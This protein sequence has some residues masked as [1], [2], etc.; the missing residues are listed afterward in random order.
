MGADHDLNM[1]FTRCLAG[2]TDY[3]LGGFR[4]VSY[5]K[6]EVVPLRPFVTSTRCHMLAMYVTLESSL[7]LVSDAPEAYKDQPGFEFIREVPTTWDETK[8]P[9]AVVDEY[10]VTAR[11]KGD[12][13]YV[14]GIGNGS[15]R[16][17]SLPLDF[18]GE[19]EYSMDLYTDADDCD[20]DPNHLVKT[21]R[22]VGKTDTID[23]HLAASGGFA[24][25][26]KPM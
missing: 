20:T 5:D 18:L 7:A 9:L 24:A 8:V 19:G 4:A 22:N 25:Q 2:E 12:A 14:G 3:H 17:I 16:D 26:I 23:I 11:K 6:Y 21:T 10:V 15:P 1:P 13:W